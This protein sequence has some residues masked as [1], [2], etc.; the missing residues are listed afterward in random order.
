MTATGGGKVLVTAA[1]LTTTQA[2]PVGLMSVGL[3][4]AAKSEAA[5]GILASNV[6]I[7]LDT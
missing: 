4:T 2:V 1:A 7:W 3:V 5:V 6:I